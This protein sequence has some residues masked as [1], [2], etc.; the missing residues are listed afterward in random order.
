MEGVVLR[1]ITNFYTDNNLGMS[2]DDSSIGH[3]TLNLESNRFVRC[4]KCWRLFFS[5][6]L[7]LQRRKDGHALKWSLYCPKGTKHIETTDD[8]QKYLVEI[9]SVE[10]GID[11]TVSQISKMAEEWKR[12]KSRRGELSSTETIQVTEENVAE[13]LVSQKSLNEVHEYKIRK[14]QRVVEKIESQ[15]E[16]A[17]K[18]LSDEYMDKFKETEAEFDKKQKPIVKRID[19]LQAKIKED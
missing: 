19:K 1:E 4:V 15:K 16:E 6:A 14:Q 7:V 5:G 11:Y 12:H 10:L 18:E 3:I 8:Y 2:D 13:G 9:Q 17:L